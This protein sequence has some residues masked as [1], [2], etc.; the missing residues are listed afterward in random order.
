[1][2]TLT[3]N[4]LKVQGVS[5]IKRALEESREVII[6]V[7]GKPKYVVMEIEEYDRLRESEIEAAWYQAR[8]DIERGQ[9]TEETAD[10]HIARIRAEL[11]DDL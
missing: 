2:V 1:M 7:R 8:L 3:A 10:E 5:S 6:S 9:Y 4:K 11:S